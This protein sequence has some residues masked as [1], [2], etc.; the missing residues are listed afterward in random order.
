M[1]CDRLEQKIVELGATIPHSIRRLPDEAKGFNC[2]AHAFGLIES[3]AYRAIQDRDAISQSNVFFAGSKF[4][5]FVI[6][7]GT[8]VEVPEECSGP[9]EIV[10]YLDD[11]GGPKH[12]GKIA[13]GRFGCWRIQ[14]K[15]G[16]GLFLEHGLWEVPENYGSQTKF[17]RA[18]P[19]DMAENAFLQFVMTQE[20]SA[21]FIMRSGLGDLFKA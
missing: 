14:S 12:A 5:Q 11:K 7:N 10:M 17:Y 3:D 20:G 16:G 13:S 19:G 21:E 18:L 15:W 2:F 8:L 9:G 1:T 6:K 4:S